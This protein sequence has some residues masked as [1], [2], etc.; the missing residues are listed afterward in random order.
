MS[1][2][3]APFIPPTVVEWLQKLFPLAMPVE[4]DTD[5]S[6]WIAVGIQKVV[7]KVKMVSDEQQKNVL[8]QK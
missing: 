2:E 6:I 8:Q 5:R 7:R 3:N 4:A 1:V